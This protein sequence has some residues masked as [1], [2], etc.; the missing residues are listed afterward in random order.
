MHI[1][2]K[3]DGLRTTVIFKYKPQFETAV[4]VF[5]GRPYYVD[6]KNKITRGEFQ[7][8]VRYIGASLAK[9]GFDVKPRFHFCTKKP[10][11]RFIR[12][13]PSGG[14]GNLVNDIQNYYKMSKMRMRFGSPIP[15]FR[16]GGNVL[17]RQRS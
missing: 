4:A 6:T 7:K 13:S 3:K 14:D 5:N 8:T 16:E 12:P 11:F 17:Y 1:V 15:F 9:N 10:A 2:L